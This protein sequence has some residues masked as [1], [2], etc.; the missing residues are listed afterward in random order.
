MAEKIVGLSDSDASLSLKKD[1]TGGASTPPAI[2]PQR[3]AC[4][5]TDVAFGNTAD[6]PR[7]SRMLEQPM[8]DAGVIPSMASVDDGYSSNRDER[9]Y[10]VFGQ[11]GKHRRN[12]RQEDHRG[13]AM[14]EPAYRKARDKR[15]A[16]ESLVFTLKNGFQFGEIVRRT[17]ESASRDAGENASPRHLSDHPGAEEAFRPPRHAANDGLIRISYS[18]PVS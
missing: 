5:R 4:H 18:S 16:I 6:R 8:T 7:L 11:N 1:G 15:S 3:M 14:E 9:N 13:A 2:G 12:Q 10:W 17:R